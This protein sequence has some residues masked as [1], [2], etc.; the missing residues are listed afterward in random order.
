MTDHGSAPDTEKILRAHIVRK[1]ELLISSI[2]RVGVVSSFLIILFGV[3]VTFTRHPDYVSSPLELRRVAG[4]NPNFPHN[5]K[6]TWKG[7][8]QFRG[9]AIVIAGLLL[10]I[11]IPV[12]RV[13]VSVVAFAVQKDPLF[14]ALTSI[15]LALLIVSFFLGKV[16]G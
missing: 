3:C 8:T 7:I 10:L 6:D 13:A 14:V 1:V 11:A 12:I 2:L 16:E 4:Q 9:Q 15:V 5:L